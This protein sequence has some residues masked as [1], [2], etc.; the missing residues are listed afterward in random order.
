VASVSCIYGMGAPEEYQRLTLPLSAGGHV[1]REEAIRRLVEMQYTRTPLSLGRGQFRVRGD[2]L[3]VC[4]ASG[5]PVVR[6][7]LFDEEIERIR[8]IDPITGEI[9]GEEAELTLFPANHY[10][11]NEE[12]LD[13]ALAG[14]ETEM[15]ERIA[16][17]KERERWIEAE[18]IHQR[19]RY[20]LEMIREVGS[21]SGIENYSRW[22]DGRE[23]GQPPYTLLSYFGK[24]WL[25]VVDESHIGLPQIH[26]QLHGDRSRK[27][28]LVEFGFRLPSAFDNRPL[29]FAEFEERL[30][31]VICSSATPGPYELEHADRIVDLV[32]RPTGLVDPQ[33]I[34]RPVKGQIDDLYAEIRSAIDRGERT[35]VT[36]L[37]QRQSEDLAGYLKGLGVKTHYLHAQIDTLD[38]PKLLRD[39][40]TGEVDVLVG[41]NLLRE[42]LDL[43]EV[44]FIAIL[45]ADQVGFLRSATSLI[46]II[47]RAARNV[48]G[49]VI[50]YAE[51]VSDAMAAAI[52]ETDRR[53]AKQVAYNEAHGITPETIRKAVRELIRAEVDEEPNAAGA[54]LSPAAALGLPADVPIEVLMASLEQEMRAAAAELNF[55]RAAELRDAIQTL[56]GGGTVGLASGATESRKRDIGTAAGRGKGRARRR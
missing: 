40:R 49:R 29:S 21:C 35:L 18:R 48:N 4:P 50:M 27:Q 31:Q 9:T 56:A 44:S 7:E 30:P 6:V 54:P 10:V 41:I 37:T 52:G 46:Q 55:E 26:S 34:V 11:T 39:L 13:E 5:G 42:G 20:D 25:M 14:I 32:V 12:R 3:E 2:V 24:D 23:P 16:Y 53:R 45:D 36:C 15:E 19:T 1:N 47:G 38:R 28:N 22:L 51:R 43:P 8:L 33:I 17:F